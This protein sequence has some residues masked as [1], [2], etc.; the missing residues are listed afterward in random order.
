MSMNLFRLAGDMTHVL[1]ILVLL[2]RLQAAKNANGISLKTQ[3]LYL[4]RTQSLTARPLT[5]SFI[6]SFINLLTYSFMHTLTSNFTI[7]GS[8]RYPISG[9]INHLYI[10]VQHDNEDSVHICYVVHHLHDY[11]YG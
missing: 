10:V 8:V 6:H 9:F 2:L 3:E 11:E 7:P 1:S 5:H 4:V